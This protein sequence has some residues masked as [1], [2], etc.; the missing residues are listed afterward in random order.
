MAISLR[1]GGLINPAIHEVDKKNL[2]ELME[3]MLSIWSLRYS[4]SSSSQLNFSTARLPL[5]I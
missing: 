4:G 1:Q 3:N 5:P 2:D